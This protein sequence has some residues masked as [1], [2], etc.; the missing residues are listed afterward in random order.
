MLRISEIA[1]THAPARLV[2]V[3]LLGWVRC[4]IANSVVLDGI[5]VRRTCSGELTLSYPARDDGAGVRRCFIRPRD[6]AARVELERE[7]LSAI[8]VFASR[9]L[10][11]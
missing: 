1:F 9:E 11:R 4:L 3:G 6:H 8:P 5:T 2:R 10:K 7:I